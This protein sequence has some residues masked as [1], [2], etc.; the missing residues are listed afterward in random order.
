[1]MHRRTLAGPGVVAVLLAVSSAADLA[2]GKPATG[3]AATRPQAKPA[4]TELVD[5]RV[6]AALD[7]L[8]KDGDFKK[9]AD[10]I[11]AVFAQVAAYASFLKSQPF[12]TPAYSLRLVRQLGGLA[13]RGG[14][15]RRRYRGEALSDAK[16]V[17]L[18]KFLRANDKLARAMAFTVKPAAEDAQGP[19]AMLDKLRAAHGKKLNDYA[20]L[21]AA[22]CVVHDVPLVRQINENRVT[23]PE[24]MKI[25]DYF[26]RNERHMLFGMR[27]VPPELLIYVVDTT[28]SIAEMKWALKKYH[29]D[30]SVGKHFFDIEYDYDHF[31]TGAPKKVTQAG[32]SLPNILKHGGV[33][34]DQAYFACSVGKAIGVP[35]CYTSGRGGDVGHAWVGFFQVKG[36]YGFWDFH[37]GR[38]Q[39]Y[40][41]VRG[42]LQDP[43]TRR[44]INDDY[45]S[46]GAE[47]M[48]TSASNRYAA[49]AYVDAAGLLEQ[50]EA[51]GSAFAPKRPDCG[52]KL[53]SEA[54]KADVENMLAL[55]EQGLRCGYG[56]APGWLTVARLAQAGKLNLA[57]KKYWANS[58]QRMCGK[59]YPDFTMAVVKPMIETIED[60][61]EQN[62]LWNA[63]FS[64]FRRREDLAAEIRMA[65]AAMWEKAGEAKKAGKCYEDVLL[66]F[67]NSG[68]FAIE[69]LKKS[70]Q[71]LRELGRDKQVPRLYHAAWTKCRKPRGMAPTFIR[72]SNWCRIGMMFVDVLKKS[73]YTSQ[74]K[75]V[76]AELQKVA[77]V[78]VA[79]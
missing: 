76:A 42:N 70:E 3:G 59:R 58:L 73:G 43:Q 64:Y 65:Q 18:L 29:G 66:R 37:Y 40:C 10:E 24:P 4:L 57:Q 68:P 8:E 49:V 69:A 50:I 71:K 62:G 25:F 39:Q 31:R 36:R 19:Y 74:A 15:G 11:Q 32:Y 23:A 2:G 55:I 20:Y 7:K 17:E 34:A 79:R 61:R 1:M 28:A 52:T 63:V 12:V 44:R 9:A 45:L 54:R 14:G 21:A 67:V 16:R 56:Y 46:V 77:G 78:K 38:Y 30:R 47:L 48:G 51:S 41:V 13:S 72:S 5:A 53:R 75:K 6:D 33:C 22:W 26:V 35:T 27:K 60:T